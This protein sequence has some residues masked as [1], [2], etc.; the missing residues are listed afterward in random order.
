MATDKDGNL[1]ALM[2]SDLVRVAEKALKRYGDMPVGI[3]TCVPGYEYNEAHSLPV[4]DAP[5][6]GKPGWMNSY[7]IGKF[8]KAFVIDGA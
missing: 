6:V 3:E 4:S 2:L 7:W 8:D 1:K 5:T